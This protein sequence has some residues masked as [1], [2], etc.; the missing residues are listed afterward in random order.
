MLRVLTIGMLMTLAAAAGFYGQR[1]MSDNAEFGVIFPDPDPKF[2]AEFTLD[3]GWGCTGITVANAFE[4]RIA[5]AV[6]KPSGF[7]V[8][9]FKEAGVPA[10]KYS[11]SMTPDGKGI[12]ILSAFQLSA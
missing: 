12:F 11:L 10:D 6:G 3:R 5:G 2:A 7:A 9:G 4:D 8:S 1:F